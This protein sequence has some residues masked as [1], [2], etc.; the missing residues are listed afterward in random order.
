METPSSADAR[1][2][3]ED[4]GVISAKALKRLTSYRTSGTPAYAAD[5]FGDSGN[6]LPAEDK[7]PSFYDTRGD[8]M[9]DEHIV[10]CLECS[11]PA[12]YCNKPSLCPYNIKYGTKRQ[13]VNIQHSCGYPEKAEDYAAVA[14]RKAAT[15]TVK[16]MGINYKND[17]DFLYEGLD[18]A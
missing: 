9:R 14:I 1:H 3:C 15:E 11:K 10:I 2:A 6:R 7:R 4:C 12:S 16:R 5:S 17:T 8:E 13:E 18:Y